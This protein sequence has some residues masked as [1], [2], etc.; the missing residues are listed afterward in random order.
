MALAESAAGMGVG[1]LFDVVLN[2]KAA[3]DQ[4]EE[5]GAVRIDPKGERVCLGL[6]GA[7]SCGY[8]DARCWQI[9]RSPWKNPRL[10]RHGASMTSP[11][12][13]QLTAR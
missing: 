2:H 12:A 10:S 3:A 11:A 6:E 5:V 1:V 9:E 7:E 4:A 13:A 8:A